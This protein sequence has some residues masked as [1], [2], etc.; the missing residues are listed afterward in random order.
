MSE[1]VRPDVGRIYRA[2]GELE[3]AGTGFVGVAHLCD[4]SPHN[5]TRQLAHL[6]CLGRANE[7]AMLPFD[8]RIT[9]RTFGIVP[10]REFRTCSR[11]RHDRV[12]M[13]ST[14]QAS[15]SPGAIILIA[16]PS[17][18]GRPLQCTAERASARA[19]FSKEMRKRA[20]ERVLLQ[21]I[22]NA[23]SSLFP[24]HQARVLKDRQM[25]RNRRLRHHLCEMLNDLACGHISSI[26]LRTLNGPR[27][28]IR[29]QVREALHCFLHAFFISKPRIFDTAKW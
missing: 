29:F 22:M 8:T 16:D 14:K 23:L 18:V 7:P 17:C 13:N 27:K 19:H 20:G 21:F 24:P 1:H 3:I 2:S 5:H 6:F 9:D 15:S 28:R 25:F 10:D 11:V 26:F 4:E 12:P